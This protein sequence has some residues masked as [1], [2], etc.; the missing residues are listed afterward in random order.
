MKAFETL[1]NLPP[2]TV[3]AEWDWNSVIC[4]I[5]NEKHKVVVHGHIDRPEF[6]VLN[7]LSIT[8][9]SEDFDRIVETNQI[10]YFLLAPETLSDSNS[11]LAK[12]LAIAPWQR[13]Y[14]DSKAILFSR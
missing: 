13:I 3:F 11:I 1:T 6:A 4:W 7:F 2:G 10:K 5:A 9:S 14:Q 12:R 8:R